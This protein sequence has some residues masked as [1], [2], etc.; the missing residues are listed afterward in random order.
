MTALD[1]SWETLQA[2]IQAVYHVFAHYKLAGPILCEMSDRIIVADGV[3]ARERQAQEFE[4]YQWKAITT[5]GTVE[6]YKHFLPRLLE[7]NCLQ[8]R[9]RALN[10]CSGFDEVTIDL[11]RIAMKLQ[12]AKALEWPRH[13][14]DALAEF[15]FA[16]WR[17]E[18]LQRADYG[19]GL[20]DVLFMLSVLGRPLSELLDESLR[21]ADLQELR[22]L[23]WFINKR[24]DFAIKR[25]GTYLNWSESQTDAP[26]QLERWLL[27]RQVEATLEAAFYRA[28]DA[29]MAQELSNAVQKIG[30]LR[31]ARSS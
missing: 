15:C 9:Q 31:Q 19:R 10:D 5:L 16:R 8:R 14:R 29:T 11:D 13:E 23:A 30:W 6:D 24:V 28:A 26:A 17:W 27:Q 20:L 21:S 25:G 2:R 4:R 22:G 12:Y 18:L 3:A 7:L 1:A